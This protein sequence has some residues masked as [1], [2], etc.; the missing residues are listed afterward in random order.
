MKAHNKKRKPKH[1]TRVTHFEWC[2]RITLHNFSTKRKS[3]KKTIVSEPFGTINRMTSTHC[4]RK[5][6]M[7]KSETLIERPKKYELIIW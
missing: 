4:Y 2:G 7:I 5:N 3:W 1:T 6:R